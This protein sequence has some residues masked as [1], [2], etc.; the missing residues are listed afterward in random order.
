MNISLTHPSIPQ[1]NKSIA[2]SLF[3]VK[4]V[5]VCQHHYMYIDK[6]NLKQFQSNFGNKN[7]IN[8]GDRY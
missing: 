4:Q 5:K 3:V 6:I 2:Y 7:M 1:P 8:I